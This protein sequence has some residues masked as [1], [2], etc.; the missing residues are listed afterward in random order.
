MTAKSSDVQQR[1][2][3]RH[4]KATSRQHAGWCLSQGGKCQRAGRMPRAAGLVDFMP[5]FWQRGNSCLW[6]RFP[7]PI[8]KGE[9]AI[10][11]C[12]DVHLSRAGPAN[13]GRA[14]RP[15]ATLHAQISSDGRLS[16]WPSSL[17][18]AGSGRSVVVSVEALQNQGRL[19]AN[20]HP[21]RTGNPCLCVVRQHCNTEC[22]R[23]RRHEQQAVV[24]LCYHCQPPLSLTTAALV[25]ALQKTP[26]S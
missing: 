24:S 10:P 22:C 15:P 12:T 4:A 20:H 21:R 26:R 23:S 13:Y 16:S 17:S 8:D 6:H 25:S 1:A 5:H 14:C 18:S 3:M 11:S 7:L 2:V 19:P 9:D